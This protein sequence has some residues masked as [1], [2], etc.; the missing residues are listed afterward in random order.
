M[1]YVIGDKLTDTDV[2]HIAY[3]TAYNKKVEK[4]ENKMIIFTDIDC[5][6]VDLT[7]TTVQVLIRRKTSHGANGLQWMSEDNVDKRF[8]KIEL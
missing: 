4:E 5:E 2:S 6:V 1:K 7:E 3:A 8:K